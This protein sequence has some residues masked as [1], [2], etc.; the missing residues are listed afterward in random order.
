MWAYSLGYL[1]IY[2]LK[3]LRKKLLAYFF[4]LFFFSFQ[5]SF[6]RKF[7]W[8]QWVKFLLGQCSLDIYLYNPPP[9][10]FP[11]LIWENINKHPSLFWR[12]NKYCS[13]SSEHPGASFNFG[14]LKGVKDIK[15]L[16]TCLFN[17]TI[18]TVII[19]V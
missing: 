10:L 19:T 18:R 15:I 13:Y 14:F 1:A 7:Q 17:Q 3:K 16:S 6:N 8:K 2:K 5:L 4:N 11:P 12:K 9:P